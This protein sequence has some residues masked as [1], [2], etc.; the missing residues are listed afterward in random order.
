MGLSSS[1]TMG[2][3][4]LVD[5]MIRRQVTVIAAGSL[6]AALAAKAATKTIPIV[7][8]MAA[9]PVDVGLVVSLNRPGG[10]ATGATN[11][12][13]EILPKRFELL[14]E[15]LPASKSLALLINPT[16]QAQAN[17]QSRQGHAAA[18]ALGRQLH[19][20]HASAEADFEAV[21]TAL[22]KL[23]AGGLVIGSDPFFTSRREQVAAL[24]VRYAIPAVYQYREYAMAGGLMSFGGSLTNM[25]RLTGL[26]IGR[27]LKGEKPAD[28]PVQQ[29][30]KAELIINLKTANA[31]GINIPLP[32]LGRADEVIE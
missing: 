9:D 11:L 8:A 25:Y 31:L 32:L 3:T 28:L 12:N 13:E 17:I 24:T 15:V 30:T 14:H 23:Q 29:A 27:I 22:G 18:R 6:A 26:Y 20:L 5:D 4:S 2:A 7:F 1:M 21:F 19:I 10:N 16:V